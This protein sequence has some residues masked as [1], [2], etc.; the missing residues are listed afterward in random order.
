MP[1][2]KK[3]PPLPRGTDKRKRA[4]REEETPASPVQAAAPSPSRRTPGTPT[5]GH[6]TR[7]ALAA[8]V[9]EETPPP[10]AASRAA[11][12]PARNQA[13]KRGSSKPPSSRTRGS[14]LP[15]IPEPPII[16]Q[17]GSLSGDEEDSDD[18]SA[19]P[20]GLHSSPGPEDCQGSA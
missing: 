10:A 4:A 6:A 7:L 8:A 16:G 13:E 19:P 12:Q 1:G 20:P 5:H 14:R 17:V 9:A 18:P 11:R 3:K 2:R 15:S